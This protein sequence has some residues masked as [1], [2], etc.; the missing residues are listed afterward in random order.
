[1]YILRCKSVHRLTPKEEKDT[2]RD[3]SLEVELVVDGPGEEATGKDDRC[4]TSGQ[5][6]PWIECLVQLL[7]QDLVMKAVM[8]T[9]AV[10][11]ILGT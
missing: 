1:V 4:V 6:N 7:V 9:S 3:S 5:E 8:D 10:A 11:G 2:N